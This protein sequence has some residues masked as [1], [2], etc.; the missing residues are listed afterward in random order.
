MQVGTRSS[1]I[2]YYT[3]FR[4]NFAAQA[5]LADQGDEN[6]VRSLT[7]CRAPSA[8]SQNARRVGSGT[9]IVTEQPQQLQ[10]HGGQSTQAQIVQAYHVA[11]A[12]S[13][14]RQQDCTNL[15]AGAA[16]AV[17][18]PCSLRQGPLIALGMLVTFPVEGRMDVASGAAVGTASAARAGAVTAER[19]AARTV[20]AGLCSAARNIGGVGELRD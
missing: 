7:S 9:I 2:L 5:A 20:P 8:N 17:L 11:D 19:G 15:P 3:K 13:A 16:A 12:R 6:G 4:I 10:Q 18:F 1:I 14:K